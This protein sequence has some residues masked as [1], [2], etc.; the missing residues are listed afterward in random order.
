MRNLRRIVVMAA[1]AALMPMS[2]EAQP[3]KHGGWRGGADVA[4][5]YRAGPVGPRGYYACGPA[6]HREVRCR[7]ARVVAR[8]DV[9]RGWVAAR[10]GSRVVLHAPR[11]RVAYVRLGERGLR[12]VLGQGTVGRIRRMARHNGIRG[13]MTG[14]WSRAPRAGG[15]LEI[16]VDGRPVA[17]LRDFNGDGHVD[18]VFVPRGLVW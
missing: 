2:L 16:R 12:D 4:V 8:P 5:T 14:V 17:E 18:R 9:R 15:T 1:A 3:R 6:R 11:S 13:P 10:W 7:S